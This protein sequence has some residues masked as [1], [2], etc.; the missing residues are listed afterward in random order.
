MPDTNF[1]LAPPAHD[2]DG[3]HAAPIDIQSISARLAF[4]GVSGA[5]PFSLNTEKGGGSP[6]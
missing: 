4:D 5:W 1:D 6:S 3:L 2:V